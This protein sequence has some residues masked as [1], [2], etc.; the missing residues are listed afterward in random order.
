MMHVNEIR[1]IV[2]LNAKKNS[3]YTRGVLGAL[4][5]S[6]TLFP[7]VMI[8][9]SDI[10]LWDAD[11][12][13]LTG[14]EITFKG[15]SESNGSGFAI[16]ATFDIESGSINHAIMAATDECPFEVNDLVYEGFAT[17]FPYPKDDE[18]VFSV[19]FPDKL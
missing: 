14:E 8:P 5:A 17:N 10:G 15:S 16:I 1:K 7:E 6:G 12:I 3:E 19:A 18:R 4:I 11:V 13:A 2:S 9:D